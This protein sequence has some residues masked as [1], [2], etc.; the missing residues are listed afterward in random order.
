MDSSRCGIASAS[1][2]DPRQKETNMHTRFAR[3]RLRRAH[4]LPAIFATAGLV[5]ALVGATGAAA[6][7]AAS[8]TIPITY[9]GT[10]TC[11]GEAFT[12]TGDSHFLVSENVSASGVV[13]YHLDTHI[14]GLQ[15]VGL[16]SGKRYVVQDTFDHEFVF[17]NA[18]EDTFDITAHFVR[19]GEDGTLILGDDFYE[20]LR[21]HITANANGAVTALSVRTSDAPCQ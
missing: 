17:S 3:R 10:N 20:Y 15:A 16:V 13:Q 12:G 4:V 11:T 6:G 21:T 14:D 2:G 19:V 7:P 5:A 9:T 8:E 18:S 1:R